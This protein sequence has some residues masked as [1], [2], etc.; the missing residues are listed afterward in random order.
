MRTDADRLRDA[1]RA[2]ELLTLELAYERRL[3]NHLIEV[4]MAYDAPPPQRWGDDR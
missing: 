4:M 1:L 3:S 2:I